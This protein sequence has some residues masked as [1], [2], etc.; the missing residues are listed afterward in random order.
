MTDTPMPV[1]TFSIFWQILRRDVSLAWSQGGTGT[2]TLTFFVIAISLFPFGIGPEPQILARIAPGVLWVMA[3]LAGLL[4]LDRLYQSDF[5][6]GSLDQLALSPL[7]LYGV[8]A[9]KIT[10]HFIGILLPLIVMLPLLGTMLHLD[11]DGYPA[12]FAS[13]LIG[14]PTISLIGSIGAAIT[15]AIR[16]GGVLLSLL[17]LPLYI[18]TLIFGVSAIDAAVQGL[19]VGPHLAL[20]GVVSLVALCVGPLASAAAIRLALE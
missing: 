11:G 16:R 4:S 17:I 3:M 12:L 9:A 15:V 8:C 5:E 1:S 10:A 18:P 20:L 6:D 14:A 7:G 2:M 19:D 13:F